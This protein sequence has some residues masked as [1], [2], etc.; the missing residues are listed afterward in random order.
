MQGGIMMH[1]R[2]VDTGAADQHA[3]LAGSYEDLQGAAPLELSHQIWPA[4]DVVVNIAG[5]LDIATADQAVRYVSEF[6]DRRCGPVTVNLATL[7]FCD[8]GGLGA[9]L[10]MASYAEQAGCP[11]RL[12]SARPSLV[13]IMRITGLYHRLLKPPGGC[14]SVSLRTRAA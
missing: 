6:I 9:L 13:K 14:S 5:E 10:R 2:L 3:V 7:E 1:T 4:G 8:A 12:T 11:F